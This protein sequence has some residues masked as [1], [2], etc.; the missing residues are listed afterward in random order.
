M[1]T[2]SIGVPGLAFQLCSGTIMARVPDQDLPNSETGAGQELGYLWEINERVNANT[3]DH[4]L[5]IMYWPEMERKTAEIG[6]DS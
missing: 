6:V 5:A 2:V 1:R 4:D 3:A